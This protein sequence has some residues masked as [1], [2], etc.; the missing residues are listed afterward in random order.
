MTMM[1]LIKKCLCQALFSHEELIRRL[2]R[3]KEN[4]VLM[5]IVILMKSTYSLSKM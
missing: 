4:V 1:T 5:I 2:R 3:T